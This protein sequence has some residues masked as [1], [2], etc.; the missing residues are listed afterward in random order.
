MQH[1]RILRA[2][3]MLHVALGIGMAHLRVRLETAS[4]VLFSAS[5]GTEMLVSACFGFLTRTMLVLVLT[6]ISWYRSR[7]AGGFDGDSA[8]ISVVRAKS[9]FC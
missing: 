8:G 1:M 5:C 9:V 2:Q 6:G 3:L 7:A 4:R